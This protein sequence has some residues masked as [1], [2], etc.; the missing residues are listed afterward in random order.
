[1]EAGTTPLRSMELRNDARER[2][3]RVLRNDMTRL[4]RTSE[5]G[6]RMTSM[7]GCTAE[8]LMAT[9]DTTTADL[10][11]APKPN[12]QVP[13]LKIFLFEDLSRLTIECLG[14]KLNIDP[15]FFREQIKSHAW[16]NTRDMWATSPELTATMKRRQWVSIR[17]VRLRYHESDDSFQASRQAV[18]SFNMNRRPDH[19]DNHCNRIDRPGMNVSIT[20]TQTGIWINRD[21]KRNKAQQIAFRRRA[22]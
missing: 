6:L 22:G 14:S 8:T 4:E 5:T 1:M 12:G 10:A 9:L 20:R 16:H 2:N 21:T 15:L 3:R 7:T 19:D 13:D 18:S 11:S 17:N